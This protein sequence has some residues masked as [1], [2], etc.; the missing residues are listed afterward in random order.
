MNLKSL[1]SKYP[2]LVK[3]ATRSWKQEYEGMTSLDPSLSCASSADELAFV[4]FRNAIERNTYFFITQKN[5]HMIKIASE[6]LFEAKLQ[7]FV[8]YEFVYKKKASAPFQA[9]WIYDQY[10][11]L[12]KDKSFMRAVTSEA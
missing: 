2:S 10:R 12:T 8:R 7:F 5:P 6:A 9:K 3:N 4:A 11:E 1:K